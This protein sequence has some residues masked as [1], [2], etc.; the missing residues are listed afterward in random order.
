MQSMNKMNTT[1]F[2]AITRT[3]AEPGGRRFNW[4]GAI[5]ATTTVCLAVAGC[6]VQPSV[7]YSRITKDSAPATDLTDSFYLQSST[8][9]ISRTPAAKADKEDELSVTSTP[10]EY[11]AFKVGLRANSSWLGMV[12]TNVNLTKI[13]NTSLVKS[14]GVETVDT[15]VD[16]IKAIGSTIATLIPLV[17]L[18]ADDALDS[19]KLP[20]TTKTYTQL[21][22]SPVSEPGIPIPMRDGVTMTLGALPVDA[23]AIDKLPLTSTNVFVYSACRD[24]TISFKY[25]Q[26]IKGR[27][28]VRDFR[29]TVKIADPR[30][31]EVVAFPVKGSIATHSECG[32]SVTT[33]A[34]NSV[35][36]GFD[37][38]NALA[39]QGKA[40]KEAIDASKK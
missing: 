16:T 32:V 18:A 20:W 27:S 34:T 30:F 25:Q 7:T 35:S 37:L 28:T 29:K 13:D 8:I 23:V 17:A 9:T 33:S 22:N 19:S 1:G 12:N 11:P 14:A 38:V 36:S 24:A 4:A 26:V 2:G 21:E 3:L 15:R 40:I 6:A 31:F 39:V 5:A 10:A